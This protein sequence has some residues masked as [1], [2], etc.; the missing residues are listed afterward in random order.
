MCYTEIFG[1]DKEGI[2]YKKAE[3]RNAWRGGMAV[4]EILE[5]RYLPPYIP[6]YII[7]C[8]W[9]YPNMDYDEI[10]SRN[11]FKPVRTLSLSDDKGMRE[12]WNLYENDNVSDTDKIALATTFDR[13]VVKKEYFQQIIDAFESF[14]GET[15]LKEQTSVIR[16]MLSDD[17]CIAVGW[18][19]TSVNGDTW[20]NYGGYDEETDECIPYNLHSMDKHWFLFE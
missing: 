17:N 18:N 13:V 3:I 2:A 19:Q 11:G 4:W 20:A 9:Y 10:V 7:H 5:E 14:E 8:K 16:E 6:E 1:F 12:V 15:S